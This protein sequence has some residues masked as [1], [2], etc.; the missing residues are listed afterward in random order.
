MSAEIKEL[1][2]HPL[3]IYGIMGTSLIP[4]CA[5]NLVDPNA[6]AEVINEIL[7]EFATKDK[8]ILGDTL[9]FTGGFDGFRIL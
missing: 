1:P 9:I 5:Y 7:T 8:V 4:L 3:G 6:R 2:L